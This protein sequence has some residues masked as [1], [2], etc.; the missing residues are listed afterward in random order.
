MRR[1]ITG[2]YGYSRMSSNPIYL[3][4]RFNLTT[5]PYVW[6]AYLMDATIQQGNPSG[7]SVAPSNFATEIPRILTSA[8]ADAYTETHGGTG[9]RTGMPFVN[10]K[11]DVRSSD[12]SA[13]VGDW[14]W[15]QSGLA[16]RHLVDYYLSTYADS[17]IPPKLKYMVDAMIANYKTS[18]GGAPAKGTDITSANIGGTTYTFDDPLYAVPYLTR[19]DPANN[20]GFYAYLQAIWSPA[21]AFVHAYYGG[22]APDGVSYATHYRRSVNVRLVYHTGA[23]SSGLNWSWKI[24]GETF[25]G[26]LVAAY[27][28]SLTGQ[29]QGPTAL[30]TPTTYT[31]WPT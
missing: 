30:R 1:G 21:I 6:I 3:T 31:T 2:A 20:S 15:F 22:N 19:S 17:R 11:V 5:T 18:S 25:G 4:P 23:N 26:S 7:A 10:D 24:W 9:W 13:L 27:L 8:F 29:P 12:T 28:M 14:P 16:A